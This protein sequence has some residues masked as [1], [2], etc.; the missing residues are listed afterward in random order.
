VLV[1]YSAGAHAPGSEWHT[2]IL[3]PRPT[4]HAT[5]LHGEE[6]HTLAQS[7]EDTHVRIH[8]QSDAA[9]VSSR[10]AQH[11]HV[12]S[13][14]PYAPLGRACLAAKASS[15]SR[16]CGGRPCTKAMSTASP[17]TERERERETERESVSD[18]ERERP[19]HTAQYAQARAALS[20]MPCGG[21]HGSRGGLASRWAVV[22]LDH[23]FVCVCVCV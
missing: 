17:S 22:V 16:S 3:D 21:Q 14:H 7:E 13:Q 18:R 6:T 5:A 8:V 15:C 1:E 2:T 10:S 19:T 11:G 4:P 9:Q 12:G 23:W 20:C